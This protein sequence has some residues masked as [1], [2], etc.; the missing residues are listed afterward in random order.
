MKNATSKHPKSRT[1]QKEK[2][3]LLPC[4]VRT[5]HD[6][7]TNCLKRTTD[8]IQNISYTTA[9]PIV[10]TSQWTSFEKE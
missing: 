7:A 1:G 8:Y 10:T 3:K 9:T 6:T 2:V 4:E 5:C